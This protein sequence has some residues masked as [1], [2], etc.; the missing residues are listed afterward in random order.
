L[1]KVSLTKT[2]R[3]GGIRLN[4]A[5]KLTG[6]ILDGQEIHVHLKQFSTLASAQAELTKIGFREVR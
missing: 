6:E 3:A 1:N 2:F 5:S 4:E